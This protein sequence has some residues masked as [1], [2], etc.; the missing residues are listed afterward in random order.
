MSASA[1]SPRPFGPYILTRAI[2]TDPLGEVWRG[3]TAGAPRLQ[4]FHLLRTFASA[5]VDRTALLAA[6]ETAVAL[7]EEI[8]GPAV[9]R[10]TVL[11]VIDDTPF[12]AVEYVEGRTLDAL[13]AARALGAVMPAEHGLLIA[14]R[15]LT[16]L[17]AGAA[18][19]RYT[20]APHGFL[21]P[22]FV[23]VSNEGEARVFGYGL[24]AGL[25]PSLASPRARQAFAPYIAPEVLAS[26][27]PGA[28]GDLYGVGAILFEML[29]GKP[30]LPGVALEAIETATLGDRRDARP[31]GPP[32]PPA[33]RAPPRPGDARPQR[34]RIPARPFRAPLRGPV[35]PVDVQPRI[36]PPEDLRA[37]DPAREGGD[38]CRGG[39]RR[40]GGG[41]RPSRSRDGRPPPR[42]VERRGTEARR[43]GAWPQ[44][45]LDFGLAP[46]AGRS[47]AARPAR[48]RPRAPHPSRSDD[49][50]AEEASRRRACVGRR[51]RRRRDPR[52][53]RLLR[54]EAPG[55]R[56]GAGA[57][58]RAPADRGAAD[59]GPDARARRRRQGRPS[60]PG[61]RPEEARRGAQDDRRRG[62]QSSRTRPRRRSRPTSKRPPRRRTRRATPRTR[63]ASRATGPTARR[64]R[65][66]PARAPRSGARQGPGGG[67]RRRADRCPS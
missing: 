50:P 47:S 5:A 14:E 26:G 16:A 43:D 52:G 2:G 62:P 39:D 32:A 46:R 7:V 58:A 25:L 38:G 30:P 63:R 41:T 57:D 66:S 11:G 56:A 20:G 12:L 28:A 49:R 45:G 18:V 9:A 59:A 55:S 21:V 4:P 33:P 35:R 10:G 44:R 48:A 23:S 15:L 19:E 31:R 64:P 8:K 13:L 40:R 37:G 29:T 53:G 67:R 42:R 27:K 60:L 24:G 22:A 6:M 54:A 1:T 65:A 34:R 61:G 17:E 36:L 51:A 3:G